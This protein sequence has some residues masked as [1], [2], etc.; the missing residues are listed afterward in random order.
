MN[1]IY[2]NT[3]NIPLTPFVFDKIYT[4]TEKLDPI[5][6]GVFLG[7]YVLVKYDTEGTLSEVYQ[8]QNINDEL[9]YVLIAKFYLNPSP[10]TWKTF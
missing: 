4:S 5:D 1:N 8:K 2:T 7:R 6:D 9:T 3:A 10:I